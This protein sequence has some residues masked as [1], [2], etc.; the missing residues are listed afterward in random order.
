M[1]SSPRPGYA[2]ATMLILLGV[3]LFAASAL[4]TVSILES[5][6][7]LSERQ[8]IT[9]YYV[10]EAGISDGMWRLKNNSAYASA[11]QA[12]TLNVTYA[13]TDVPLTGDSFTVTMAQISGQPPGNATVDVTG[14]VAAGA[15]TA[16]RR[17]VTTVFLG[18][19]I[20]PTGSAALF[21]GANL[22]IS[23]GAARISVKGGDAYAT[24]TLGLNSAQIDMGGGKFLSQ[25]NFSQNPTPS[26]KVTN[27]GGIQAPNQGGSPTPVNPPG[28][29]FSTAKSAAIAAGTYYTPAQFNALIP[30]GNSAATI[31]LP[32]PVTYVD[33]GLILPN[34][35]KNK[36]LNITGE[37][38]IN[39]SLD[40]P[41]SITGM[42]INI[43]RPSSGP[44]GVFIAGNSTN[45]AG[46]WNINGIYYAAG[47][48]TYSNSESFTINGALMSGGS[49]TVNNGFDMTLN[50]VSD[51]VVEAF[52][53]VLSPLQVKHWE[54]QY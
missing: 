31:S 34:N 50:F 13:A 37:L 23:N 5:K 51:R 36:T 45:R 49:I 22:L 26:S 4:V 8:G 29:S 11:L 28:F 14:S 32:G 42:I 12:G 33:G 9:A 17:I 3:C 47:N 35:Y 40:I 6:I 44:S 7:S 30:S 54:E 10:S 20:P 46:T 18:S 16:K 53:G 48:I 38:V 52:G 41:A 2:L 19:S 1:R 24:G 25:G 39:G 21:A 43:N 27:V 15:I